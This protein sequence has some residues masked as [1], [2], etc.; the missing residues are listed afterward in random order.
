MTMVYMSSAWPPTLHRPPPI[1]GPGGTSADWPSHLLLIISFTLDNLDNLNSLL[2]I[3]HTLDNLI[4][5][6][7]QVRVAVGLTVPFGPVARVVSHET[8]AHY[9]RSE[10]IRVGPDAVD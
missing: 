9:L 2:F 1:W 8:C 7:S 5:W 10:E 4:Y 3:G 6:F